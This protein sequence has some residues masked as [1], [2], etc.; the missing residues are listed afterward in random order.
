MRKILF[1]EIAVLLVLLIVSIAVCASITR[2]DQPDVP[3]IS[4][5]QP[6]QQPDTPSTEELTPPASE[7]DTPPVGPTWMTTPPGRQLLAQQYFVY[8]VKAD[9]F[10]TSNANPDERVYPASVTKLF[11]AYV[12]MQFVEPDF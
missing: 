7:E 4:D 10:V 1:I 8:D 6:A 12:A 9:A 3:A 5:D 11:T 2:N